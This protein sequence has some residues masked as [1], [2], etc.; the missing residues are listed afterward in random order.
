[1]SLDNILLHDKSLRFS[2]V[3]IQHKAA[4]GLIISSPNCFAMLIQYP[5][6]H[7]CGKDTQP[8][9]IIKFLQ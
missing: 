2:C 4:Y 7:T 6:V 1:L 5:F 9:A 3:S 8:V